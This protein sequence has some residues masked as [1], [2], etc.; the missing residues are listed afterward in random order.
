MK[1]GIALMFFLLF[2]LA[3]GGRGE[4]FVP[5]SIAQLT[6]RA[7]VVVHGTVRS[8]TCQRDPAGRICTKVELEL[9]GV[10]KGPVAEPKQRF[11]IVLAG[12]VL[13]EEKVTVSGQA[14]YAIGEEVVAFLRLNE[15]GEG[16]T[17]GLAQG[18]FAVWRDPA[19]GEKQARSLFHGGAAPGAGRV[20]AAATGSGADLTLSE[21]KRR[22]EEAP[23]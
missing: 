5:L 2:L 13:G 10:W 17:L 12:G 11:L 9:R 18:K 19:T 3:S 7:D 23:R 20:R 16:V 15:R 22:V 4:Q 8:K 1:R 14:D 21:L 6:A